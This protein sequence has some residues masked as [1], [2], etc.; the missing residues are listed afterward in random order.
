MLTANT[1]RKICQG[2]HP[3]AFAVLGPHTAMVRRRQV[4]VVRCFLPGAQAVTVLDQAGQPKGQLAQRA[5][6]PASDGFFEGPSELALEAPYRLQVVWADGQVS[7]L[8]DPYRFALLLGQIDV[9]LLGEGTHLRPFEVLGAHPGTLQGV[10][11]TRFAVWA[12]N[13]AYASVVG[14]F[15]FWDERRHPMRLRRE[16]GV[17]ELFLPAVAPGARYKFAMRRSDKTALPQRADPYALQ[18]ELRPAT[19]SVVGQLPEKVTVAAQRQQANALDAPVSIYEVHLGSWRRVT[20]DGNRWLNW[21]ELADTL[22]PY[23]QDMGFTHIELLPISEHP[24]DGSWGYQPTGLYAPTARFGDAAGF[25]RLVQRCHDAGIGL[26]LD[27]VPAHFPTD[28]HGLANFDGTHLYEYADPREGFHQDWN[29]LIYN[30]GRTEVRNFLVGNALYWLERFGVDGLRVDAVASMLY[31]DY[32]RKAGEWIPNVHGGRENLEAIDFLKRVNEVVG[33]QCPQAITLAE[34]STAYPA[35]SRPTYAGGLGFHYKWNMG[36]MHDTLTYMARDPLYRKHH[37][38]EMTFGLVYAFNENF[39]L[40][41]S[42]DEVVHGKGSL[43]TKMPGDRWQQLANVR[44][45]LGF[46]WAHPGKK[47]LFMGCEF[48]QEREW[49]FEASLDWHLLDDPAHA[50][51]QRLV[52][53][54]NHLY[55]STPA[56]YQQDFVPA[57]FAWIDHDD[58][59]H[60]VLSFIRRGLDA[61]TCLV[62]VC[63]FTP[64]VWAD[65]RLGV[66]QAGSYR[67]RINTD[68]AHYGGS[69]V[70]NPSVSASRTPWHGQTHSIVL[71]L[72]PLATVFFEWKP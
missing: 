41:I 7:V 72:P 65:Y 66:P 19:A 53:D 15:N 20:E 35:V 8:D 62:V 54:L 16:C 9:W 28:A 30:L 45:Y 12:P 50:G 2:R 48:A 49:N 64:A 57:G 38:G 29:T 17:W 10:A 58:A 42:H 55:R 21:D 67:E 3:D 59:E 5:N 1:I 4:A 18:S 70:G 26:M 37:Q 40:P 6:D 60:S 51:I 71:T 24:F 25:R 61:N 47:L 39:V 27:W 23:V 14:D 43:L 11:G 32:S 31:R 52:R 63:N 22:V 13:A 46:M 33:V 68:S 56:L 44:A 34:E 36:W 69:N